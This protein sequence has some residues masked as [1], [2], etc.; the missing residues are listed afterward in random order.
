LR[1]KTAYTTNGSTF[2]VIVDPMFENFKSFG[3]SNMNLINVIDP[4]KTIPTGNLFR[5][6]VVIGVR[7]FL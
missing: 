7:V 1:I 2:K 3:S 5:F 4:D 6:L